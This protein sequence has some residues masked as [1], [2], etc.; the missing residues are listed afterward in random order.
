MLLVCSAIATVTNRLA[1]IAALTDAGGDPRSDLDDLV[2]LHVDLA[3]ALHLDAD[4]LLERDFAALRS[5][6]LELDS[7]LAPEARAEL[8]AQ[9]EQLSSRIGAAFLAA[10]GLPIATIDARDLLLARPQSHPTEHFLSATC[11]TRPS[12]RARARIDA[13]KSPVVVTQGF[14]AH[15]EHGRTVLLG[16]GGSDASAAY[17]AAAISAEAV[18]IR[19]DVPGLFTADPRL[20]PQARLLRRVSYAEAESLA[21]LGA[22]AL[23]P[24]T[25]EPLRELGIPL[26][27]GST[28]RP[29][30]V[31]TRITGAR[32]PRGVKAVTA[33]RDLAML[34]M[35]RPPRFQPV[36]FVADVAAKFQ[37]RGLSMDLLT[38]SSSEI[39]AT[40]DLAAFPSARERLDSLAE[41]L[42]EVCRPRVVRHVSSMSL[43]GTALGPFGVP[44]PAL[45][46]TLTRQRV[47][48]FVQGANGMHVTHV[49]E[50]SEVCDLVIAA[51]RS[52]LATY[53]D[54][55]TFGPS[56]ESFTS[57]QK[58][59]AA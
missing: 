42:R 53:D 41:D 48:F 7:P 51:H 58:E 33:R 8:L 52:L 46:E 57:T 56:W 11:G 26:Y 25:I 10:R 55:H 3:L 38:T 34:V 30:E 12:A 39:R 54:A 31:G 23:H 2:R 15:D 13:E 19:S 35:T 36:G 4:A 22:K 49:V 1:A 43:V 17:L 47:H 21:A 6:V 27:L 18:E 40:V 29:E 50:A 28:D 14:I 5:R 32:S 16:R 20:C 59:A 44:C 9:G 45:L 24:R 37:Q